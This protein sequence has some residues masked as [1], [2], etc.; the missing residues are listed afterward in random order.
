MRLDGWLD[1]FLD[2]LRAERG[3]SPRTVEAYGRDLARWVTF[4]ASR[5]ADELTAM[6]ADLLGAHL[7]ALHADGLSPR[8]SARHL[9]ALRALCRFLLREQALLE[10]PTRL[11]QRPRVGRR[12][13]RVLG[14]SDLLALIEAPDAAT[15][16]GLRDRAMLSLCYSSGLRV[17]ELTTLKLADLDRSRGVVSV[18]GKGQ[19]RRLVPVGEVALAHVD[20]Y[21]EHQPGLRALLFPS[22]GG[23]SLTRQ[24]FWKIVRRHAIAAGL[25]A[26]AHPHLLRHAFATHLLEGGAD[27]RTVQV[28]LGHADVATTEI[29]THVSVQ[30]VR[31]V[32][33]R[34]HPRG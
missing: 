2:H 29:Y 3:A 34:T 19:K 13:P 14:P 26:D 11:L 7:E 24:A 25:P 10:D 21:L 23:R 4:A 5:G 17:S 22:R 1:A 15:A 16:R 28:L 6:N 32:H 8:S 30:R 12:L 31:E 27:L 18:I 20:A 9:S 33:R